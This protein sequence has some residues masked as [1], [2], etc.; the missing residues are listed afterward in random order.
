MTCSLCDG[1][2]DCRLRLQCLSDWWAV[3][4]FLLL[5]IWWW[6]F[7]RISDLL[8][9]GVLG[10]VLQQ[11]ISFWFAT[12][13]AGFC[14]SRSLASKMMPLA[15]W[16]PT[17]MADDYR[18]FYS[19]RTTHCYFNFQLILKYLLSSSN[20][21]ISSCLRYERT[22]SKCKIGLCFTNHIITLNINLRYIICYIKMLNF[23]MM[24]RSSVGS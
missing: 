23:F 21:W 1:I 15:R 2:I 11:K 6:L 9:N 13:G 14:I 20:R 19:I 12:G 8:T 24:L 18:W 10:F 3:E 22:K 7:A 5:V 4:L 17:M 16:V